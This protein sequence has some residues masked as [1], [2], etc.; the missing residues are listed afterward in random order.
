[1][2]GAGAVGDCCTTLE[3]PRRWNPEGGRPGRAS[4]I[5]YQLARGP[6]RVVWRYRATGGVVRCRKDGSGDDLNWRGRS[7][8][9]SG[10]SARQVPDY[11]VSRPLQE[12]RPWPAAVRLSS[13]AREG[14]RGRSGAGSRSRTRRARWIDSTR[15]HDA[16]TGRAKWLQRAGEGRRQQRWTEGIR[17]SARPQVRARHY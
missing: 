3:R 14:R 15:G 17:D 6:G 9:V 13:R 4:S 8:A 16:A 11:S 12:R 10:G 2:K 1:M 7:G 5:T